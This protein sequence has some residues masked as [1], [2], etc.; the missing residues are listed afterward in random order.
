MARWRESSI[1]NKRSGLFSSCAAVSVLPL[2]LLMLMLLVILTQ[3]LAANDASR[4]AQ[5]QITGSIHGI[6][7]QDRQG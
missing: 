5:A 6:K 3:I 7:D 2:R 1:D 4:A